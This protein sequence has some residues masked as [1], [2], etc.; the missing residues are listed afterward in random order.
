MEADRKPLELRSEAERAV[1]V[2]VFGLLLGECRIVDPIAQIDES[3]ARLVVGIGVLGRHVD[4]VGAR[5]GRRV[6][7]LTVSVPIV[8]LEFERDVRMQRGESLGDLLVKLHLARRPRPDE[9]ADIA[10]HIHGRGGRGIDLGDERRDGRRRDSQSKQPHDEA[11]PGNPAGGEG[12]GKRVSLTMQFA[13]HDDPS[14]LARAPAP[15]D[16]AALS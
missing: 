16:F 6:D 11:A 3:V 13:V 1:Q 5:R 15:G 14:V 8:D 10:F 2:E 4:V 12:F 7:L 9:E